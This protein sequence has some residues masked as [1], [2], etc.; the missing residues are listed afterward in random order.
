M[1]DRRD[2]A[3]VTTQRIGVIADTHGLLRPAVIAAFQVVE[4]IIHAGDSV[5]PPV[6][7]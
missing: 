5:P 1:Q 6:H 3:P 4:R 2:G 7:R